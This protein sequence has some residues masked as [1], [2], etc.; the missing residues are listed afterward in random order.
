MT[1]RR[2]Q[3]PLLKWVSYLKLRTG[4]VVARPE[5]QKT[6][7][8]SEL[9][10]LQRGLKA[11]WRCWSISPTVRKSPAGNGCPPLVST[12][13]I[14]LQPEFMKVLRMITCVAR[15]LLCW[16]TLV[17]SLVA[18]EQP[19]IIIIFTDDQGYNDLGCFGSPNIRTPNIDRMANE[20][21]RLTSLDRKSVV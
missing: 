15:L 20:G 17:S 11:V 7:T 14:P 13:L 18:A 6:T 9:T 1:S 10:R 21:I 3:V 12:D 4:A 16:F 2:G 19:N 5:H 8:R